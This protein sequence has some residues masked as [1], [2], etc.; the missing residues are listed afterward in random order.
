MRHTAALILPYYGKFPNYFPL[1]LKSAGA[2]TDFTFMIFT[3]IDMSGCN[4]P[5]NVQ[6]HAMTLEEI[7][8][9][10]SLHLHFEPV[11]ETP[12]KLCD[13]KPMF[14]L[15]FQDWL[16]GYDFWGYVDPD[17]IWGRMSRFITDDIMDR[18]DRIYQHGHLQLFRNNGEVCRFI[19]HKLPNWNISYIDVYS[20]NK[21]VD[22]FAEFAL[23]ENCFRE[24]TRGVGV[25]S[26]S[27]STSLTFTRSPKSSG[28]G[29]GQK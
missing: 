9:R 2:N 22:G 16:E 20:T 18:Y 23:P 29:D 10:A 8:L 28:C 25:G 3:D 26:T 14:G 11:L 1:W 12:Y 4:I 15:I 17:V 6:V 19:L 24:F 13:Y 27:H 5:P 7:R 21:H